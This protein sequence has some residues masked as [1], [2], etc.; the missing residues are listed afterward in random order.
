MVD[1]RA[2]IG[3]Q[4][5]PVARLTHQPA[6]IW[7]VIVGTST[8]AASAHGGGQFLA[9]HPGVGIAQVTSNN[10]F[11]RVSTTSGKRRVTTTLRRVA[12]MV[13]SLMLP[14]PVVLMAK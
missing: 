5:Q 9:G 7:S 12:G 10:S 1:A 6:S 14:N 13:P 4:L 8:S 2:V 11:I 3:D